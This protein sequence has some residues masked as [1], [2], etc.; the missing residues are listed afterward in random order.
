MDELVTQSTQFGVEITPA[1]AEGFSTLLKELKAWNEHTNLTAIRED[2]DI[3]KKHFLDSI[4][5]IQAIPENTK[6]LIDIGS[7]AGFP[8]IPLAIL[9][10]YISITLVESVGKKTQFLEHCKK[11]LGLT[12]IVVLNN[13]AEIIA[14]EKNYRE[15]FDCATARAVAALPIL[16]EYAIPLLKVHGTFIAQKNIESD[17]LTQAQH[18]LEVLSAKIEKRIP[19]SLPELQERE[20]IIIKKISATPTDYPRRSGLVSKKPL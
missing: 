6:T 13:R 3:I 7:G 9:R 12:N 14:H 4:T 10:P 17:E 15:A 5:V 11:T 18:A 2:R 1:Q 20:L 19:I 16:L 8:G